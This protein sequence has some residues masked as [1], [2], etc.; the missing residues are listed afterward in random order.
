[1]FNRSRRAVVTLPIDV[2]VTRLQHFVIGLC[3]LKIWIAR[4]AEMNVT[5]TK[6][7]LVLARFTDHTVAIVDGRNR[8]N[9]TAAKAYRQSNRSILIGWLTPAAE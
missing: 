2:A 5:V 6:W 4:S 1:M 7:T 8:Q 9:T 3:E